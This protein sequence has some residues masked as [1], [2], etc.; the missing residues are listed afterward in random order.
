MLIESPPQNSLSTQEIKELI[1]HR[2]PMLLVDRIEQIEGVERCVGI[3]CVTVNEPFFQGHFPH[4]P[5]MPG[6]LIVE[7]MAQT[8]GAL[9]C[10]SLGTAGKNKSVLF[11]GI[12][13][14][15]FRKPVIPGHV[16]TMYVERVQNRRTV[17]KFKG[18]ARVNGTLHAEAI[19]TAM[20]VDRE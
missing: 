18:E 17:W 4:Y 10:H 3:K 16:L 15:R 14:A 13:E 9:V 12:D 7:A 19:F 8:A 1:P 5:I 6:V 20:I 11:M 2:Y